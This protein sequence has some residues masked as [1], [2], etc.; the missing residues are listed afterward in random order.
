MPFDDLLAF[1][2]PTLE[3]YA[4]SKTIKGYEFDDLFQ[5][6]S[7]KLWQSLEKLPEDMYYADWRFMQYE[8]TVFRIHL[9]ELHRNSLVRHNKNGIRYMGEPKDELNRSTSLDDM[10]D[11]F[12]DIF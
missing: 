2:K 10:F 11:N 4:R 7:L 6:L 1:M 3:F 5:E 9:M 8:K 12:N